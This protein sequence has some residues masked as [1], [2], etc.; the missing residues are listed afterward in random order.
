MDKTDNDVQLVHIIVSKSA[1]AT[2]KELRAYPGE[3]LHRVVDR[4]ILQI[5]K[6]FSS[7]T[8]L[9]TI[10]LERLGLDAEKHI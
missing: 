2:L 10:S 6:A 9:T 7:K 1:Q 3:G 5:G 4:L 8:E